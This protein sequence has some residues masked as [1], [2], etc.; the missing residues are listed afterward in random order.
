[1]SNCGK[2]CAHGWYLVGYACCC[3]LLLVQLVLVFWML[4]VSWSC[5]L[6][7]V[8][9]GWI[10][11]PDPNDICAIYARLRVPVPWPSSCGVQHPWILRRRFQ[12]HHG[13][14]PKKKAGHHV[15]NGHIF[16]WWI[17]KDLKKKAHKIWAQL[18]IFCLTSFRFETL[19]KKNITEK[20]NQ[21]P[22][23]G[24]PFIRKLYVGSEWCR[25]CPIVWRNFWVRT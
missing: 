21:V 19:H 16:W 4:V 18:D 17:E 14:P 11:I 22:R 23:F 6:F 2:D 13:S 7:L 10:L 1:M 24:E 25:L 3:S 12:V 9:T 15:F 5:W 20:P 8:A